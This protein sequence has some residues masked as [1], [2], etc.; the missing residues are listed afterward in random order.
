MACS[1]CGKKKSITK[2]VP[3]EVDLNM[4]S[5][6]QIAQKSA[7]VADMKDE[8]F[9]RVLY[10]SKNIGN[11]QVV[12]QITKINY[13]Y[14]RGG[15]V[16]LL[17]KKDYEVS[18]NLFEQI[19]IEKKNQIAP[20][21]PPAPKPMPAPIKIEYKEPEEP[22]VYVGTKDAELISTLMLGL[23]VS[24]YEELSKKS[25]EDILSVSGIGKAKLKRAREILAKA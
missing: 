7:G 15:Q 6:S 25:D 24:T 5:L 19:Q 3:R 22:V 14:K 8:D 23:S 16:M 12:G 9:V 13:G 21:P 20:E 17:H 4:V 10:K 18:K 1:G 11:H 2:P